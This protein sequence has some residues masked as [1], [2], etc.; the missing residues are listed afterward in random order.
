MPCHKLFA[1]NFHFLSSV[2]RIV[3]R[4]MKPDQ[5]G[6]VLEFAFCRG[7]T[8]SV[9]VGVKA[10]TLIRTLNNIFVSAQ[11]GNSVTLFS[12]A[13]HVIHFGDGVAPSTIPMV[14]GE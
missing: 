11:S 6:C 10:E 13:G 9:T 14:Q 4:T 2:P 8:C 3:Y 5:V 7:V 12:S 1:N